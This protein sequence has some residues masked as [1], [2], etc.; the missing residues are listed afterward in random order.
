MWLALHTY[1]SSLPRESSETF[2]LTDCHHHFDASGTSNAMFDEL[3]ERSLMSPL[4]GMK[5]TYVRLAT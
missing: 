5:H 4:A 2:R 3:A 1:V